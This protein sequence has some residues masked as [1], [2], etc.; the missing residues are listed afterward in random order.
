MELQNCEGRSRSS[1]KEAS[2]FLSGSIV[3]VHHH[4]QPLLLL[5]D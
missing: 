1:R 3:H 2:T 5:V 4:R